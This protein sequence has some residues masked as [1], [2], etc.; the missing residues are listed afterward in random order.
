[1]NKVTLSDVLAF[2]RSPEFTSADHTA[3]VHAVNN[4][5]KAKRSEAKQG[6]YAGQ[7]VTFYSTR[8]FRNVTGRIDKINRVNVDLTEEGTGVKWRCSPGLLKPA[9]T[10]D[11]AGGAV[12]AEF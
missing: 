3:V 1:M 5:A 6:L 10:V 9:S 2:I 4:R 12:S 7:R 8:S 11:A